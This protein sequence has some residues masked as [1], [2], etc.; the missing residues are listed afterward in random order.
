MTPKNF[1]D[2]T[3]Q[4]FYRLVV[5]QR[6]END[7]SGR[8][9]WLC[10]CNCGT[11]KAIRSNDLVNLKVKSCGCFSTERKSIRKKNY[12]LTDKRPYKI[13][14]GIKE[15]CLNPNNPN[16]YRYGGRGIKIFEKWLS[17]EGFWEDMQHGYSDELSIDRINNN[18]NYEPL[19]CRWT[20]RK[21]Q[22]NNYSRN[23]AI[24]FNGETHNICEWGIIL[25]IHYNTLRKRLNNGWTV[26][27][28]FTRKPWL[29]NKYIRQKESEQGSF[30]NNLQGGD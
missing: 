18:G 27:E 29:G 22:M 24:E 21:S 30:F 15:R 17:F 25:G 9:C 14:Q 7:K 10:K 4:R 13:W 3:G 20:T 28:A 12:G 8:V 5:L 19:N 1:I 16:Y 11:E 23:R 6:S 2:L 26:E